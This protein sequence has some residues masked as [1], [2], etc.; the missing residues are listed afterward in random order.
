M[1]ILSQAIFLKSITDFIS[2]FD[3]HCRCL[4]LDRFSLPPG[5]SAAQSQLVLLPPSCCCWG[6]SSLIIN[7]TMDGCTTDLSL[8][9]QTQ[10]GR[11]GQQA[12][13]RTTLHRGWNYENKLRIL[14]KSSNLTRTGRKI[15]V[16]FHNQSLNMKPSLWLLPA[17]RS[18]SCC[19][20][21]LL[22]RHFLVVYRT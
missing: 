22:S 2:R 3:C 14:I 21:S 18:L 17:A 12:A 5:A 1:L 6:A 7:R 11:A 15:L 13:D 4:Y 9:G 8:P 16:H 10:V 19:V 20:Q